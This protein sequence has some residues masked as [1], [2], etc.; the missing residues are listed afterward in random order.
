[1]KTNGKLLLYNVSYSARFI[2]LFFLVSVT[3]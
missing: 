3:L 2:Q 1:M